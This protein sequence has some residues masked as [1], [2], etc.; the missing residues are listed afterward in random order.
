M[1]FKNNVW[2]HHLNPSIQ[3]SPH[4][5][6]PSGGILHK[7]ALSTNCVLIHFYVVSPRY[8]YPHATRK[9]QN[10][11]RNI[12]ATLILRLQLSLPKTFLALLSRPIVRPWSPHKATTVFGL[13]RSSV[14]SKASIPTWFIYIKD[15]LLDN[16]QETYCFFLTGKIVSFWRVKFIWNQWSYIH[17]KKCVF[18]SFDPVSKEVF[19]LLFFG[20][21]KIWK[22]QK[23]VQFYE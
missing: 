21:L 3:I 7:V 5:T 16:L 4:N 19:F 13:K 20:P 14:P 2:T 11:L 23:T 15:R 8:A 9:M 1:H 22:L 18:D 6:Y 10:E 12:R 17:A